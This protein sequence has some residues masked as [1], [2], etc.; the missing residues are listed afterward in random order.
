[1]SDLK[2]EQILVAIKTAITGLTT[3]GANV[4]RGQV[5]GHEKISLPALTLN[6]G[7]DSVEF[8]QQ[9]GL[10][11]WQLEILIQSTAFVSAA[12]TAS[13][14]ALDTLLNLIRGEVYL[15]VMADHTLGLSFV[16][17]IMPGPAGA[18]T[19]SGEGA[20]PTGSQL[21]TFIV[22]YRASRTDLSA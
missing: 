12:Y 17:D 3:T 8:E 10:I 9:T 11:D 14:S 13:E 21:L 7:Q 2:A 18:P 15:A 1:M 20:E 22:K 19:L 5:Y 6:M 4:Q 16:I